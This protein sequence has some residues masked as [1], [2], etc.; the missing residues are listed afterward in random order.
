RSWPVLMAGLF[1]AIAGLV[2]VFTRPSLTTIAFG[3]KT[4]LEFLVAFVL[5]VLVARPK[6]E[7]RLLL[8]VLIP[9]VLVVIFGLLQVY[10]L[11]A[12]FLKHFGY[13]ASTI[14][15]YETLGT[16]T[17]RFPSTL[18]GPNQL[19]TYL[20][21]P[22]VMAGLLALRRRQWWWLLLT[23][24]AGVVLIHTYS[25][26]AWL[27]ALCAVV[28]VTLGLVSTRTRLIAAG[29]IGVLALVGAIIV[30]RLVKTGSSLRNYILHS[31][32]APNIQSSDTQHLSSL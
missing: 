5:A 8:A 24:G 23:A 9:A 21:L 28:V 25:R 31:S 4:D 19:G 30:D 20:I 3:A 11:P 7:K 32:T 13:G 22:T 6:F 14:L 17:L 10:A 26:A 1:A 15:P 12:G 27:G 16:T 29:A 18:G 2:T